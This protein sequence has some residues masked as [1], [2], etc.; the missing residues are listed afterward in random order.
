MT[1]FISWKLFIDPQLSITLI[2]Q[3]VHQTGSLSHRK[4][5]WTK[6]GKMKYEPQHLVAFLKWFTS[7]KSKD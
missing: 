7:N 4:Q 3:L 5:Y 1:D 2:A 6:T